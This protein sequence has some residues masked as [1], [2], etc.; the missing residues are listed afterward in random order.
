[1]TFNQIKMA[2]YATYITNYYGYKLTKATTSQVKK[3]I[4][5]EYSHTLLNKLKLQVKVL[6]PEK[7]PQNGQYLLASNHR[8]VIDP[9]I[10]EIATQNSSIFGHWISKKELYNSFFFGLFVRNAGTILLDRE[11]SQMGGFFADIKKATKTGDS[12]YIFPEGTRNKSENELGE[13]KDGSRIIAVKNRLDILPVYI[14][15]NADK[16]LMSSLKDGV[17]TRIIEVEFGD[18]ISYKDKSETLQDSFYKQ[19]KIQHK[20]N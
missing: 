17:Q 4:R 9:L 14:K 5:T 20:E 19:F 1:M 11:K 15:T 2:I 3:R 6:N 7:I 12:I 18:I 10:I 8:S 13:F 16:E